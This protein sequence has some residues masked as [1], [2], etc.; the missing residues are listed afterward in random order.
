MLPPTLP[1]AVEG[2]NFSLNTP[3]YTLARPQL[4]LRRLAKLTVKI[5]YIS[6]LLPSMLVSDSQLQ[7][8]VKAKWQIR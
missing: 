1:Q 4:R 3:L 2:F 5:F 6:H 7:I 8:T